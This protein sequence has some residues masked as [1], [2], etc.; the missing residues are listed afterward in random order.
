[1]IAVLQDLRG[2]TVK[3]GKYVYPFSID[4]PESLPSTLFFRKHGRTCRVSYH[5]TAMFGKVQKDRPFRMASKALPNTMVPCFIEPCTMPIKNF[6][7]TTIGS[8]T[9]GA[10]VRD[11]HVGRGRNV[12]LSVACCNDSTVDI[13]QVDVKLTQI[14]TMIHDTTKSCKKNLL[15]IQNIDLPGLKKDKITQEMRKHQKKSN[16]R[17]ETNFPVIFQSLLFDDN[18]LRIEIPEVSCRYMGFSS[19]F[20]RS[21]DTHDLAFLSRNA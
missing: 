13:Q 15:H 21:S 19:F 3:P 18:I 5:V 10:M 9:L 7:R 1:M 8:V 14:V 6:I 16:N 2:Q 11:A 17:N 4:L 20:T 12:E